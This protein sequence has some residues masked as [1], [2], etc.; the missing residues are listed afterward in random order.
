MK[1]IEY[2]AKELFKKYGMPIPEGYV[3]KTIDEV[4]EVLEK[5]EFPVS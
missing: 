5:L 3:C 4:K 1:L 2:Q